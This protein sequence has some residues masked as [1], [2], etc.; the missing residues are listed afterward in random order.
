MISC[1]SGAPGAPDSL[2]IAN[3]SLVDSIPT[4]GNP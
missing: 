4:Q 1:E 3:I 2:D